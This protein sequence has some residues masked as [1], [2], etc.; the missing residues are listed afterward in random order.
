MAD[1]NNYDLS[2]ALQ[3]Y[4]ECALWSTTDSAE[5]TLDD[6]YDASDIQADTMKVMQGDVADFLGAIE[7]RDLNAY[8]ETFSMEALGHDFWLTRNG[9]GAGF[10]DRGLGETGQRLTAMSKPYGE[11][12]LYVDDSNFGPP[13]SI[14]GV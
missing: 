4:V 2:E 8:L 1:F 7:Q 3:G 9:H 13:Y 12:N 14:Y 11:F 5:T 10:W 6:N